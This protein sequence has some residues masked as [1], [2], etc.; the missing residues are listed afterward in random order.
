MES[1]LG[2]IPPDLPAVL[3]GDFNAHTAQLAPRVNGTVLDRSSADSTSCS[4]GRWFID[5]CSLLDLAVFNG[6]Q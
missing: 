1:I 3:C 2:L 5:Q 4:R 6:L